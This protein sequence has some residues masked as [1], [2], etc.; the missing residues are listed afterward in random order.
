M[1]RRA[2]KLL[3]LLPHRAYR[4]G[5]RFGVAA[6]IEHEG[7]VARLKPK[8]VVDAGANVGQFSLLVR[9]EAPG[10]RIIA[11]EPLP[12]AAARYRRL[13]AGDPNVALHQCALGPRA[14]QAQIHVSAQPDSS[15]LLPIGEEQVRR[16]PGTQ[17]VAVQTIEVAPLTKFL[18]PKDIPAKSLLKIDVQGF[19]SE[20]LESAGPLLGAFGAVYAEL[21]YVRLYEGQPLAPEVIARLTKAGF[22]APEVHNLCVGDD[23]QELQA[24]FLFERV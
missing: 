22:R 21:S 16:F 14:G 2:R 3:K 23:G 8:L 17:E 24:D 10:A 12:E 9:H 19:E 5:L 18:E 11:F 13:F 6:V 20:V 7:L 15:S 4:R 1:L